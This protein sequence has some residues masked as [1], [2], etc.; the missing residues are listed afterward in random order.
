VALSTD[1]SVFRGPDPSLATI[2]NPI[3]PTA[4]TSATA[5][6]WMSASGGASRRNPVKKRSTADEGPSTSMNT[7]GVVADPADKAQ[8]DRQ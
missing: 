6:R 8:P 5:I 1:I 2:V 3:S 7:R 4:S